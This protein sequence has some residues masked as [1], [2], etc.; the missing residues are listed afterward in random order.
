[1][2]GEGGERPQ[3]YLQNSCWSLLAK[4]WS[5]SLLQAK[6]PK[7]NK[8]SKNCLNKIYFVSWFSKTDSIFIFLGSYGQENLL[9]SKW[10][11]LLFRHYI[12]NALSIHKSKASIWYPRFL[13]SFLLLTQS[14]TRWSIIELLPFS[15]DLSIM[16]TSFP[17]K[18][19]P[20]IVMPTPWKIGHAKGKLLKNTI[21]EIV[22]EQE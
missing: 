13:A 16:W 4:L 12:L 3:K 5:F 11:K 6:S 2:A 21:I 14:L 20:I 18:Y 1:M 17:S 19:L 15:K 7:P 9:V 10:A 22:I 8:Q